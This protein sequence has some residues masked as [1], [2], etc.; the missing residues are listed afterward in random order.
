[1]NREYLQTQTQRESVRV[2]T[3]SSCEFTV[4]HVDASPSCVCPCTSVSLLQTLENEFFHA[5]LH[6]VVFFLPLPRAVQVPAASFP[7]ACT[8]PPLCPPAPCLLPYVRVYNSGQA[9]T[10]KPLKVLSFG[11]GVT[12][13]TSSLSWFFFLSCLLSFISEAIKLHICIVREDVSDCVRS[14][15]FSQLLCFHRFVAGVCVCVY[16]TKKTKG[17]G[18]TGWCGGEGSIGQVQPKQQMDS[19][20]SIITGPLINCSLFYPRYDTHGKNYLY[21]GVNMCTTSYRC[22]NLLQYT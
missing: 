18:R 14:R 3:D 16:Q 8:P 21:C 4:L 20:H 22:N 11:L 10:D 2:D 1:M 6:A 9:E 13:H 19:Q 12:E 7:F 15:S 17:D 5:G